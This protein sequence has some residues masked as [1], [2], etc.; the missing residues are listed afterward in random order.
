MQASEGESLPVH[1]DSVGGRDRVGEIHE[2]RTEHGE[3]RE[4]LV[5]ADST[6]ERPRS[7]PRLSRRFL[8]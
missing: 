8:G 5:V 7:G 2:V 1:R 4:A 6:I 3:P